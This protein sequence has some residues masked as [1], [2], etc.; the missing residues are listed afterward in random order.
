MP[1][2]QFPV[3]R[4]VKYLIRAIRRQCGPHHSPAYQP[5]PSVNTMY[6]LPAPCSKTISHH[7]SKKKKPP[8][9]SPPVPWTPQP[10]WSAPLSQGDGTTILQLSQ[11]CTFQIDSIGTMITEKGQFSLRSI[12]VSLP[13][14][15]PPSPLPLTDDHVRTLGRYAR[16]HTHICARAEVSGQ[17]LLLINGKCFLYLAV[18]RLSL[19]YH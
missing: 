12:S 6:S 19:A 4:A 14:Q 7:Q 13:M 5:S 15:G 3:S 10:W 16:A 1:F 8:S 18:Y 2:T 11:Y 9:D 17:R